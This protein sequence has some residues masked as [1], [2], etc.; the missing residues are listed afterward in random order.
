GKDG[1]EKVFSMLL[2]QLM[3][4]GVVKGKVVVVDGTAVKAYSQRD[5]ENKR[6]KSDHEAR[7]GRG[8]RGFI[9]GYKVHACMPTV[10]KS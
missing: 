2:R 10:Q 6:G 7:V 1:Y 8:R 9:L 4:S 3:E 5:L